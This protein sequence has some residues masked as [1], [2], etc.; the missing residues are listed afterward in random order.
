MKILGAGIPELFIVFVYVLFIAIAALVAY[1]VVKAAVKKAILEAH[2]EI[3]RRKPPQARARPSVL[4][5]HAE[6][7]GDA[8]GLVEVHACSR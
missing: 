6:A 8:G 4:D 1:M 7:L 5:D 2:D 3:E